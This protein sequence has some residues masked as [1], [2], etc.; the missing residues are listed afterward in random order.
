MVKAVEELAQYVSEDHH[1]AEVYI[2]AF[3][4]IDVDHDA[5]RAWLD[6][7]AVALALPEGLPAYLEEQARSGIS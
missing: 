1:K 6:S 7:L 4:A 3:L 2:S 5:E